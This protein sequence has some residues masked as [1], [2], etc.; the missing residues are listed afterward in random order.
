MINKPGFPWYSQQLLEFVISQS[1]FWHQDFHHIG[2]PVIRLQDT[3]LGLANNSATPQGYFAE[4][5]PHKPS[6]GTVGQVKIKLCKF[7][8]RN[9]LPIS[10]Q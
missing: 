9:C 1:L 3:G 8:A 7:Y 6:P 4:A 5:K 2:R 10:H